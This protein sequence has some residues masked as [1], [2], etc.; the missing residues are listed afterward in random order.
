M[1]GFKVHALHDLIRL[2]PTTLYYFQVPSD[3]PSFVGWLLHPLGES[4][5][6]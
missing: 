2:F 5:V 3:F 4:L 6:P 1:I